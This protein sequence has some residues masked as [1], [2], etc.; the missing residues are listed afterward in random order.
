MSYALGAVKPWVADVANTLG[1]QLNPT[2][3]YGWRA[4][5]VD[6]SGHPAGLALDWVVGNDTAKGQHIA[7]YM[8]AN[9]A[10]LQIK[11]VIWQQKIWQ[12]SKPQWVTMDT[13]PG[14]SWSNDV[15]HL[16]HV[17]TSFNPAV[18]DGRRLG[19][20][21]APAPSSAGGNDGGTSPVS[22]VSDALSSLNPLHGVDQIAATLTDRMTWIRVAQVVLGV[23][24]IIAGVA[25]LNRDVLAS[26]A[27]KALT[28]AALGTAL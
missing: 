23:G 8:V 9:A 10:G 24:A 25:I 6:M 3:I 11:Y 19:A 12:A 7:D 2:T 27:G 18:A 17:H 5:S 1:P 20:A 14:Q 4:T 15:N 13:R 21:A 26:P 28:G 22:A 16:Y